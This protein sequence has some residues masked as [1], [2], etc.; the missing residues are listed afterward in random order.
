M[1]EKLKKINESQI[2]RIIL[3]VGGRKSET[4]VSTLMAKPQSVLVKM[5]SPGGVKPY[6]VDNMYTY[7]LI[8]NPH[9]FNNILDYSRKGGDLSLDALPLDH[10]NLCEICM[11]AKFNELRHLELICEKKI[12]EIKNLDLSAELAALS[13]I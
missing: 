6:S 5:I 11:E 1:V 2:K 10:K 12:I 7:F 8:R 4:T 9:T 13:K 3:N